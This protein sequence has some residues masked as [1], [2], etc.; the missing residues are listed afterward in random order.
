MPT[1]RNPMVKH[2][3]LVGEKRVRIGALAVIV[4]VSD[5]VVCTVDIGFAGDNPVPAIDICS[6]VG[7]FEKL[8]ETIDQKQQ[9]IERVEVS[10]GGN[11]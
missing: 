11:N 2:R 5:M 1:N 4:H 7:F 10:L 9:I 6:K 8:E 3:V